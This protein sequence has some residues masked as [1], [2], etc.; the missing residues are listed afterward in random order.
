[1]LHVAVELSILLGFA[2]YEWL[3]LLSGGMVSA[4]YL[5]VFLAQPWRVASTLLLSLATSLIV[6]GL[7]HLLILFGRRR[8]IATVLVSMVLAW[9]VERSL[10]Y[11]TDIHQDFRVVGYII[12]GLIAND[13]EKQGVAKTL[14]VLALMTSIIWTLMHLGLLG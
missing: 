7:Q 14:L 6:K 12:P 8:F 10:F 4:G 2:G 3:G 5:A 11:L 13:M 9:A 1:M